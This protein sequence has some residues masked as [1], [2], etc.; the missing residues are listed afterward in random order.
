MKHQTSQTRLQLLLAATVAI[1]M[2]WTACQGPKTEP[3]SN[4]PMCKPWGLTKHIIPDSVAAIYQQ[5]FISAYDTLKKLAPDT[6]LARHFRIPNAE[7]FS[8]DA[9][10]AMINY[11][12]VDS[13][14]IFYGEDSTGKFR[15]I[16]KGVDIKGNIVKTKFLPVKHDVSDTTKTLTGPPYD[17]EGD[18]LENGQVCP[19]CM[20]P[21]GP[22]K[23]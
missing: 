18:A 12:C 15:L 14:R 17:D 8:K 23:Y 13:V 19:P 3:T 1:V 20:V 5:R 2:T 6:F 4:W 7:T 10:C 21:T 9:I 16:I 22:G 11:P